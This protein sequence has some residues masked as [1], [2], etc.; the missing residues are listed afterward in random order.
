[1]KR[2]SS[3]LIVTGLLIQTLSR[4]VISLPLIF[5]LQLLANEKP[6]IIAIVQEWGPLNP[7]NLSLASNYALMPLVVR[8]MTTRSADGSVLA[9]V[10]EAVP[11]LRN[12]QAKW[13]IKDAAKWGDSTPVT[14]AD[15]KLAWVVGTSNNVM[16]EARANYTKITQITWKP[17]SPKECDVTYADNSWTYDRDLPPLLPAHLEGPIFEQ[18]KDTSGA[19]DRH[20][21]YVTNPTHRGLH[22][23][24]YVL[25]EYKLGSHLIL[26]RNDHF[27][28][29]KPTIGKIIV[30][31]IADTSTLKANLATGQINAVSAV[32]FPPDLAVML[33]SEFDKQ[34]AP[35]IVRLQNSA[36]FQGV[37][38]NNENQFLK[39]PLVREA[40]AR[41]IDKGSLVKAF[42]GDKLVAAE[43]ILP[44]Q[45]VAFR[46]RPA[47]YSRAR[48][49][50][51]LEKAGWRLNDRGI[52]TKDGK[53]LSF[54][55]KTSAGIKVL[56]NIQVYICGQFREVGVEC[57]IKN[58]PPRVL[59]G[60]S[61]PRGEF[62]LAIFGQPVPP[63]TSLSSYFKS[64]E[65]PTAQ[66]SW[67]GANAI[68]VRSQE[69]DSLLGQFDKENSLAKRNQIIRKIDDFFS[70]EH[71]FIPLY[72]RREGLIMPRN[73]RGIQDSFDG[74]SYHSPENWHWDL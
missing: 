9:D 13:R 74:T 31:H 41:S 51:L 21:I 34:K 5:P 30:K 68:R 40:L 52:R 6:L 4:L 25:T 60:Q 45:H 58:E 17:S 55:F 37:H 20:S 28:G 56:E 43:T 16:V 63:D 23:G 33:G 39:D 70:K 50:T 38:F 14:C 49:R 47:I 44:L 48:A 32:G 22:N 8:R 64:V 54:V 26:E 72:H 71:A 29:A 61:V 15:W 42:F 69:L 12:N 46:Q 19:Y 3:R 10:A 66:N 67:A 35:H 59:L 11:P 62:D 1:M 27:F 2:K 57:L 36:L 65:I 53:T 24:P 18:H 7:I 73:L